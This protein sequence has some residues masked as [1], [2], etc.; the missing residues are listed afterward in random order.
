MSDSLANDISPW[1]SVPNEVAMDIFCH[2]SVEDLLRISVVSR[3]WY[4]LSKWLLI[5]S[6]ELT[7]YCDKKKAKSIEALRD[8]LLRL[9][10]IEK[11]YFI[12]FEQRIQIDLFRLLDS[13]C[14]N[15]VEI[16][17]MKTKLPFRAM[18]SI[19]N[20]LKSMRKIKIRIEIQQL[21]SLDT[22]HIRRPSL[23]CEVELST[24]HCKNKESPW[25]LEIFTD[26]SEHLVSL[27]CN[28]KR[29]KG[30]IYGRTTYERKPMMHTMI[31]YHSFYRRLS[32][33]NADT[34]LLDVYFNHIAGNRILPID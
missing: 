22:D 26:L 30:D 16:N 33:S 5:K 28:Y 19:Y 17:V 7:I 32:I 15:I 1:D 18:K 8:L 10:D 3:R 31:S 29:V 34:S 6:K 13:T 20:K 4:D 14:N 2:L 23:D 24:K 9:E 12:G 21:Y 25:F 11:V 27:V